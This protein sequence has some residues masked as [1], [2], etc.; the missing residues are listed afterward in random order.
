[1]NF[2]QKHLESVYNLN[3]TTVGD[4]DIIENLNNVDSVKAEKYI[5]GLLEM[6]E[7]K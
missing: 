4:N 3:G 2:L 5:D 7:I 6:G 1:M